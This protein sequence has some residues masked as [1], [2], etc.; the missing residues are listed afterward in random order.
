MKTIN[1]LVAIPSKYLSSDKLYGVEIEVEGESL[2]SPDTSIK[3]WRVEQD[4]SLKTEEA[5]EY[6]TTGPDTLEGVKTRLNALESKFNLLGSTIYNS[7]R[8]GVH[9]HMNVQDW[10]VKQIMTFATCYYILEDI[11]LKWCGQNRE[12]N[13]FTLRTKDAEYILFKLHDMLKN[14]NLKLLETD[15]IRY[16]SLN[17]LSLFKYVTIEFR[18]MRSTDDLNLIYKWVVILDELRQTSQQF[19]T[20][21]D[22]V[23]AMSGDGEE[24]FI[25]KLFPVNWSTLLENNS[26]YETSVRQACRRVQMIAFGVDWTALSQPKINIFKEGGGL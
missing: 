2:P 21:V 17:Y 12:G 1:Q 25:R 18:G 26:H 9:V 14:R 16:A 11:L 20:P 22:V 5:W 19:N 4:T 13:L 3:G 7:V 24:N 23:T 10:N 6:V 15:I 8:A